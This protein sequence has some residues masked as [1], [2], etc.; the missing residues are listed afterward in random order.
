MWC[1]LDCGVGCGVRII[2]LSG[3]SMHVAHVN[4]FANPYTFQAVNRGVIDPEGP[5]SPSTTRD[6]VCMD[7]VHG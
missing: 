2:G 7:H 6:L 3:Q 4:L 5:R 1:A